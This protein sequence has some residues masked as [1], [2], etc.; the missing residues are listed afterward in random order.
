MR[1]E[2]RLGC[3]TGTGILAAIVTLIVITG[4]VFA[5]GGLLYN[6]G[7]LNAQPGESLGGVTS[8]AA[9][10]GDCKACHTAPWESETMSDRCAECHGGIASQMRDVASLHGKL[11]HDNPDL[12]CRHCHPE[13]R[14][15]DAPLTLMDTREFP[16]EAVGYSLQ[17]HARTTAGQ[18]FACEDCHGTD[19][20]IFNLDTC[21][22]CHRQMDP[23]FVTAHSI[24]YGDACLNCHDGVDRFGKAFRHE[25]TF[26]LEGGHAGVACVKCHFD[27]R[28]PAD[29]EQ[30]PTDCYSCH[31]RDDEHGGR[32][33]TDCAACHNTSGWEN[34]TFDHDKSKFP[35]TGR[36]AGLECEQCHASG[37]FEGLSMA[38]VSCHADPVFHAGM[39]GTDCAAC[40]TTND[41]FASFTGSH[42]SIADEGG[43]GVNHGGASCRTC[44]T[45]TLSSATCLACH[46]SNNPEGGEGGGGEGGDD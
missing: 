26:K 3:L 22:S 35:L 18:S 13:H 17:G 31:Q 43:S 28:G 9:T 4:Y 15:V 37:Q 16:H 20:T 11:L 8:H 27:A 25:N 33:G 23:A 5:K 19:I 42:P 30:V 6:P 10:G 14:G 7:P 44:H 24:S 32:F 36:H 45:E 40:H 29:F 12:T 21:R 1:K 2:N 38:C 39:F 34:A 41:W 46:D